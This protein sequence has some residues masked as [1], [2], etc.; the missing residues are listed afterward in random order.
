[1]AN[2][3]G[4]I[5]S[6]CASYFGRT[7]SDIT[8]ILANG[9]QD[10]L[11]SLARSLN[12]W[13]LE[14]NPTPTFF[15]NFPF[16]DVTALTALPSSTDKSVERGWFYTV[17]DQIAYTI[18]YP[19]TALGVTTW[20]DENL[21]Q[22]LYIKKMTLDGREEGELRIIPLSNFYGYTSTTG[23]QPQVATIE[24]GK[25]ILNPKPDDTYLYMIGYK[26]NSLGTLS[27]VT[28]TNP[29]IEN[30]PQL[31]ILVAM[32]LC[33]R[34]YK[35]PDEMALF[36]GE[37]QK[38]INQIAKDN[39]RKYTDNRPVMGIFASRDAQKGSITGRYH[40]DASGFYG[41]W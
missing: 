9:L 6:E 36:E 37:I 34:Y 7:N 26:R 41:G 25:L 4:R 16:A 22:I 15:S 5:S 12:L 11:D 39:R 31:A 30:Y 28:D 23:G 1:M 40:I 10:E 3:L 27:A 33:A 21:A 32:R 24:G 17:A 2:N 35:S 29:F 8:A 18:A 14:V 13:F 19:T 38:Y 20:N